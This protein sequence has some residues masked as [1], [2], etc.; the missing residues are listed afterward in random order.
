VLKPVQQIRVNL[1]VLP[2]D[3]DQN[4]ATFFFLLSSSQIL[5]T[6]DKVSL[7]KARQTNQSHISLYTEIMQ[8]C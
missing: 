5:M 7:F 6:F 4:Y 1:T 3:E 2:T 8:Q